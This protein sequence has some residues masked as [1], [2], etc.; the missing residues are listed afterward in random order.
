MIFSYHQMFRDY[1]RTMLHSRLSE[2][3][4]R[5]IHIQAELIMKKR[6]RTKRPFN[7]TCKPVPFR[8]Q[9]LWSNGSD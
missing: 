1:L 3:E 6:E 2:A 8:R 9:R 4:I 7:I 5:K